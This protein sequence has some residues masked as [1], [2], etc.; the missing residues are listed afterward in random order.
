MLWGCLDACFAEQL[1]CLCLCLLTFT[2]HVY[3]N[4]HTQEI[5]LEDRSP[6]QANMTVAGELD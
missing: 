4:T 1:L 2:Q 5:G 6:W 3:T